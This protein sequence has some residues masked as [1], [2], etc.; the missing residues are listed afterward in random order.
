MAGRT[1]LG[2]V[3]LGVLLHSAYM[4]SIFDIYFKTPI[5]HGMEPVAPRIDA[6]AKRLVLFVA[7]GLRADKFFELEEN[8]PRAPF[9][10][11]IIHTKGRW[12]VSHARPPTESRPGH[13]AIIA[14][15][16][17]DPSAVTKGWK[18]N[19]V[20]FDSVFN[21]S[22]HT[23]SFG[24]PDIVPI[25]CGALNNTK[26]D[27][28][29]HE[30]E[31]FATDASFLDEWAFD[32]FQDLLN[33]SRTESDL[34]QKL[35]GDG[36][37]VFLHLLG[38]DTNGHAHRPYSP[39]YLNNIRVVDKGIERTVRLMENIFPD[40]RTAYVFTADHGMSNKGS[41]GDG[42]PANT[43]TPLVAW[44][45][46]VRGPSRA[47]PHQEK[48]DS[49]KFV[50]EHTHHMETPDGW[51]LKGL[52]RLDVNQGDIAPLMSSLLGLPCPMNSVGVVPT[53]YLA[54][55]KVEQAEVVFANAKQILNQVLRKSDLKQASSLFFKPFPPLLDYSS[56]LEQI[57]RDI[58]Q[59]QYE[60]AIKSGRNLIQ[61]AL[62]GL[63]YF[64][65][66]DWLFLMTT[67]VAGYVGWM[68]YI[69]LHLLKTY[70]TISFQQNK[71][72]VRVTGS[73]RRH[74]R[75]AG[76]TLMGV[77]S[78]VLLVELAPPLYHVYIGLAVFFWTEVLG[79]ITNIQ[80]VISMVFSS[81]LSWF[82]KLFAMAATSLLIMELLVQS[83]FQREVYTAVF[84]AAGVIGAVAV[85]WNTPGLSI[86]PAFV[87][88]ACWFLAG[89][90]LMPV[91]IADNTYL[92]VGSGLAVVTLAVFARWIDSRQSKLL[93]WR[94]LVWG[95]SRRVDKSWILFALQVSLVLASSMM[96]WITTSHREKQR[97]L[98]VIY[99]VTNWSISG[100]SMLLPLH[101]PRS[102]LT[103]LTSIY[104]GFAPPFL[105]LSIGYESL[106]YT[107]L[108][109]VLLSW[110]LV[111]SAVLFGPS[112]EIES[113]PS[114]D[115]EEKYSKTRKQSLKLMD[116]RVA[117]CFL[118]LINVAFFGTGNVASVASFEISSVYRFIT[119][120]NP[121]IM[122]ALLLC[123]VFI[124]FILV[125][126]AFSA[127][128]RLL[129]LPRFGC[130]LLVLLLSDVMTIHFFFLVR[131]TGSWLDIGQTIS[132]FGIMSA[133]VVF[134][135]ILFAITS[136]YTRDLQWA[137]E[138]ASFDV[139]STSKFK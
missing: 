63:H 42:D 117:V 62:A 46:G 35:E 6:P 25:F 83:F 115:V 111:E 36:L 12:G 15:F 65:T 113:L 18:A 13:V 75:I 5:I 131:N 94:P 108:A 40:G 61:L 1:E 98:P 11:S 123:K 78:M 127:V 8:K 64:Q 101:S 31:D 2:L 44:G 119:V 114:H 34:R 53:D 29:S 49:L 92:V 126:S 33:R 41:H 97:K 58:A 134:V 24:S 39:I 69:L 7:D 72:N 89:F 66:Y 88:A 43:E 104:L 135:L 102:M 27:T 20:E 139:L 71:R 16:Y 73:S 107:A 100:V 70:S 93:F 120:F 48:E 4:L 86:V 3:L 68:L 74:M 21:R 137:S 109:M 51:G 133:Q 9:L 132:H 99:Q 82:T 50:D 91:Q 106:F 17:E 22:R 77:C 55:E 121:F 28:Y 116:L 23:V 85:S 81:K 95:Y 125:T 54:L 87:W 37:V 80:K 38:C 30:Y 67:I 60:S 10:H 122:G 103:R 32:K 79:D 110:T 47:K 14:G 52:E 84:V 96:V 19:P 112:G 129:A 26:W 59:G 130:Y 76:G 124:P 56:L 45:A 118:I 136:V 90:T 128:T 105:L 57:E 138:Q